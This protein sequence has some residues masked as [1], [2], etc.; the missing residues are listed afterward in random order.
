MTYILQAIKLV[1]NIILLISSGSDCSCLINFRLKVIAEN[2]NIGNLI[3]LRIFIFKLLLNL[4]LSS[5]YRIQCRIL[6]YHL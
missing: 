2:G 4:N 5:N 1:S 3:K 6:G